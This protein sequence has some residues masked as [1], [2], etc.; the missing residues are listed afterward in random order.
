MRDFKTIEMDIRINESI[1]ARGSFYPVASSLGGDDG[2]EGVVLYL[3]SR[4]ALY[5]TV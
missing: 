1:R 5:N 3:E 2:S 4:A